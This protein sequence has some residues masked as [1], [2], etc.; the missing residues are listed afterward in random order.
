MA[1]LCQEKKS[2]SRNLQIAQDANFSFLKME[3]IIGKHPYG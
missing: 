3:K 1:L 2:A